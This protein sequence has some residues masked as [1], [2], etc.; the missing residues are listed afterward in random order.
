MSASVQSIVRRP[1]ELACQWYDVD[2]IH[3]CITQKLTP[4]FGG[5]IDIPNDV[6]SREFAE[7]LADQYRLAM[8][9]GAELAVQEMKDNNDG[10][11]LIV[12]SQ[13]R[14]SRRTWIGA[15]SA[16]ASGAFRYG[17]RLDSTGREER[18]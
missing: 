3:R 12:A 4:A 7:W 1:W 10:A 5:E 2:D 18:L 8:R 16:N 6:A 15:R 13:A 9:K 17:E 14:C 11:A